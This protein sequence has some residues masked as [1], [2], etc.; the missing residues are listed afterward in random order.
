MGM[1]YFN[2]LLWFI[3]ILVNFSLTLLAFRLWGKLGLFI[4]AA[5]S[6]LLANIQALKQI[7]LFGLHGSMGDISYIGIYLISDILSENYG[8][9]TARKLIGLGMFNTLATTLIMYISLQ[10]IPSSYD[11]AQGAL[12]SIFGIFPRFVLASLCAFTLS[13]SYDVVAY[14]F[15]RRKFPSFRHIWIRNG[16]ST[17]ISQL[18]DNLV[19]SL[20]AFA[21]VFPVHYIV[22]IF[23]TSCIL[24]TIIA[25]ID[26]PFVY[27]SVLIKPK[28]KEVV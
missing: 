28:I 18:I 3:L 22:E 2:E 14:Q 21:G 1:H 20:I 4:F 23:I 12:N 11:Q 26:T 24:R 19:F 27:W 9:D 15:W 25:L 7:D 16:M 5:I 8:K 10:L 13:Q 6:I 17:L